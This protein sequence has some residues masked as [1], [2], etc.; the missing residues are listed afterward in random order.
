MFT[1]LFVTRVIFDFLLSKRILKDH[2]FMLRI[3]HSPNV[4]WMKLRPVFL[5][6]S[7]ILIVS[8][9]FVFF[10][11]DNSKYDIEF[12]GGTNATIKLA[13]D[14]NLTQQD[15]QEMIRKKLPAA[16]VYGNK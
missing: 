14:V 6:V 11:R 9:L 16:N 1:A 7:G 2:L 3:I 10:S 12:T 4:N 5:T 8:G 13:K 15:I